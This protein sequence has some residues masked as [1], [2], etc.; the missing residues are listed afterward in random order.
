MDEVKSPSDSI[1]SCAVNTVIIFVALL[2]AVYLLTYPILWSTPYYQ[3]YEHHDSRKLKERAFIERACSDDAAMGQY[4]P[5]KV[6]LCNEA[7]T[8][9]KMSTQWH[10]INS[11]LSEL[12]FCSGGGCTRFVTMIKE[13]TWTIILAV[14]SLL[15]LLSLFFGAMSKKRELDSQMHGT[16][17]LPIGA[18][19]G[20]PNGYGGFHYVQR[21]SRM[22][23]SDRTPFWETQKGKMD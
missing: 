23:S 20:N 3:W 10:A 11:T 15:A 17:I 13:M 4:T 18:T 9:I 1:R 5:E 16:P 2:A 7:E 12:S 19:W 8:Y 21:D 6:R 22:K 14:L